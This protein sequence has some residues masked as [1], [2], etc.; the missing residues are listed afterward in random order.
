MPLGVNC[1]NMKLKVDKNSS[2]KK[3]EN[4]VIEMGD[5]GGRGWGWWFGGDGNKMR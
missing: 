4:S 2:L 1:E 5:G 3:T